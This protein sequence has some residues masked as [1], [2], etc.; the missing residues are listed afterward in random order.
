V[1]PETLSASLRSEAGAVGIVLTD[2]HAARLSRYLELVARW[3]RR[4]GLTTVTDPFEAARL[5]IADSLLIL[6]AQIQPG[7]SLIDVGSGAGLPG[8]PVAIVRPDLS[9]TLLEADHRKAGFLELAAGELGLNV[10]VVA[11]R[12]E[13]FAHDHAARER[14]D[15]VVARAVAPL[16]PLLELTL[17]FARI[18]GA[19]VLL[20]G[21]AVQREIRAADRARAVLGGGEAVQVKCALAGGEDR[22]LIVVTKVGATPDPYPRRA[23][24]PVRS[25]L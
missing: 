23:G 1:P 18:G 17:P 19:V 7:S 4:A 24:M 2:Q 6:R 15:V 3:R 5:H 16:S 25:P 20:K 13:E 11:R 22:R 8:I 12:A 10:G 9:V 21:P 14:Y